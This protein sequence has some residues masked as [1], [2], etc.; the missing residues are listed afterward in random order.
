MFYFII[1]YFGNFRGGNQGNSQLSRQSNGRSNP[2][3]LGS[4]PAEVIRF[5]LYLMQF[6]DSL[7]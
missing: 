7:Y 1:V 3:V 4:I 2:E 6:P 5:F